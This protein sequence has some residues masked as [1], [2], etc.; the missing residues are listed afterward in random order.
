MDENLRSL[1]FEG[2][3]LPTGEEQPPTE[4]QIVFTITQLP[5]KLRQNVLRAMVDSANRYLHTLDVYPLPQIAH[6]VL[7]LDVPCPNRV[8]GEV[9]PYNSARIQRPT[10]VQEQVH[11]DAAGIAATLRGAARTAVAAAGEPL[12]LYVDRVTGRDDGHG[13]AISP[14]QTLRRAR[15]H[16]RLTRRPVYIR[17][18]SGRLMAEVGTIGGAPPGPQ[19][20]APARA[21]SPIRQLARPVVNI[22]TPPQPGRP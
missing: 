3:Q 20:L 1:I 16:A 11:D 2:Q 4:C 14:F 22:V 18:L 21:P 5:D 9:T 19:D 17:D 10:T 6:E 13:T 8:Y 15:V 7:G 12:N